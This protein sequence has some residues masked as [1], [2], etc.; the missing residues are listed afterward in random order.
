[1]TDEEGLMGGGGWWV[2]RR[3]S[4]VSLGSGEKFGFFTNRI[5]IRECQCLKNDP[6]PQHTA[7][8]LQADDINIRDR[9]SNHCK[10]EVKKMLHRNFCA[11]VETNCSN[12]AK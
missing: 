10:I 3:L 12:E 11:S 9:S 6:P 2:A 7:P 1:M 4:I 5:S 8:Q